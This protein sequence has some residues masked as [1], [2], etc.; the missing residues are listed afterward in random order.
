MLDIFC[1]ISETLL[2]SELS[3]AVALGV[4]YVNRYPRLISYRLKVTYLE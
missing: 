2:I 4:G 1:P 3:L